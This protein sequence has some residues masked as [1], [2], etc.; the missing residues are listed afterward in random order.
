M[1]TLL[2]MDNQFGAV[3]QAQMQAVTAGSSKI[4]LRFG[5]GLNPAIC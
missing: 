1:V 4:V 3:D 2:L 5:K